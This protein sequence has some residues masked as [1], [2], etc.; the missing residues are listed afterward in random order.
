MSFYLLCFYYKNRRTQ[1]TNFWSWTYRVT[2]SECLLA[3]QWYRRGDQLQ[4]KKEENS[5]SLFAVSSLGISLNTPSHFPWFQTT[6]VVIKIEHPNCSLQLRVWRHL[7][8]FYFF[9]KTDLP[10][11]NTTFVKIKLDLEFSMH[12]SQ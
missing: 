10:F 9:A 4:P 6:L 7:W 3:W 5:W 8:R 11:L 12:T 2:H 1:Q